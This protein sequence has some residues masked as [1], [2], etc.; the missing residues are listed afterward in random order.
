MTTTMD[1][2]HDMVVWDFRT[3]LTAVDLG[4]KVDEFAELEGPV[5]LSVTFPS[6]RVVVG[7]WNRAVAFAQGGANLGSEPAQPISQVEFIEGTLDSAAAIRAAAE[8]FTAEY[9]PSVVGTDGLTIDEYVAQFEAIVADDD[10]QILVGHHGTADGFGSTARSFTAAEQ[11]GLTPA[12]LMRVV[13][14]GVAVRTVVT[15]E[16]AD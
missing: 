8:R 11:D 3:P 16:P 4:S 14:G 15:F 5:A 10:G 1:A 2:T 6:D 13:D 12:L 7:T 9:G